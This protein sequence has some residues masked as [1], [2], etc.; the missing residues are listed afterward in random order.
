M[1]EDEVKIIKN[2]VNKHSDK[3]ILIN[4]LINIIYEKEQ[5]LRVRYA[6]SELIADY[7]NLGEEVR[8]KIIEIIYNEEKIEEE[9]RLHTAY[10]FTDKINIYPELYDAIYWILRRQSTSLLGNKE[11]FIHFLEK[12]FKEKKEKLAFDTIVKNIAYDSRKMTAYKMFLFELLK[13]DLDNELLDNY[14][15]KALKNDIFRLIK[16]EKIIQKLNQSTYE[17]NLFWN[18]SELEEK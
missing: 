10:V 1:K 13:Y 2:I 9:V 12:E 3:N 14:D 16:E 5:N 11:V 6:S 17:I 18:F 7:D 4:G 15:Y 8:N